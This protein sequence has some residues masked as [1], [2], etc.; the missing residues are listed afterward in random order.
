[1]FSNTNH[2]LHHNNNNRQ[3]HHIH[4]QQYLRRM[5]EWMNVWT[6]A[7]NI[8]DCH[9]ETYFIMPNRDIKSQ[10]LGAYNAMNNSKLNFENRVQI[11]QKKE[12]NTFSKRLSKCKHVSNFTHSTICMYMCIQMPGGLF[13]H[14]HISLYICVC[15]TESITSGKKKL[16]RGLKEYLFFSQLTLMLHLIHFSYIPNSFIF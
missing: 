8:S 5:N 16:L 10:F 6:S 4:C 3:Y 9:L 15:E 2:H 14:I 13:Q 1:M 7:S 12:W 11:S